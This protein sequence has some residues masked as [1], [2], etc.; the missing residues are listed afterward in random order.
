MR[1]YGKGWKLKKL[2]SSDHLRVPQEEVI[3]MMKKLSINWE[4]QVL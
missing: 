1:E 3:Y 2:N 4:K